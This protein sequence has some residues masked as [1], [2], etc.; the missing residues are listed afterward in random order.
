[1]RNFGTSLLKSNLT[2]QNQKRI[3]DEFFSG[4]ETKKEKYR[5]WLK[6]STNN[7]TKLTDYQGTWAITDSDT[8]E[9]K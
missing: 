3:I 6:K 9:E 2:N 7:L 8:V 5:D 4:D 1:M